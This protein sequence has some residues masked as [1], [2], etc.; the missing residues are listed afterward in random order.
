MSFARSL[1]A[2]LTG[3]LTLNALNEAAHRLTA[4][5][6]AVP[7]LD[8]LGTAALSRALGLG[9]RPARQADEGGA[10]YGAALALDVAVNTVTYATVAGSKRP[11][12]RGAATGALSG[13]VALAA[14]ALLDRGQD[15]A[16][17]PA[18]PALTV[19]WYS[20]GGAAA[21]LAAR[22]LGER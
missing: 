10:V 1:A 8:R 6:A 3:A 12:L 7:R 5:D 20:V 13:A 4:P 11:V 19:L 22:A 14:A 21:G 17:R 9:V 2:G 16:R 15:V 18:T